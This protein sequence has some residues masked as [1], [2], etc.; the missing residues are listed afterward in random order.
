MF[1]VLSIAGIIFL[2]YLCFGLQL[3]P[4]RL[5]HRPKDQIPYDVETMRLL[6]WGTIS[7][8]STQEAAED[9]ITKYKAG[10]IVRRFMQSPGTIIFKI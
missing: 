5:V 8:F 6:T 10:M 9:F 1:W 4:I 7:G 2:V 3:G